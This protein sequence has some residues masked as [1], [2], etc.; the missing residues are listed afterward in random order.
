MRI[1]Y[2]WSICALILLPVV[3]V[4]AL[5]RRH[6]VLPP[7]SLFMLLVKIALLVLLIWL[8]CLALMP[9][10]MCSSRLVTAR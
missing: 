10:G 8:M 5:R 4:P 1:L 3:C 2:Y 6:A 9:V 7:S